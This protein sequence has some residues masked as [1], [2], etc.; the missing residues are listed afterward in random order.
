MRIA[1][2]TFDGFS[3]LDTFIALGFLN[4]LG[5]RGWKA[6]LA[7]PTSD[8]TSM[9]GVTVQ[10]QQ[11]LEFANEADA[12]LFGSGLYSRAIA[13]NSAILDRLQLDPLRQLVGAQCSGALLMARLGLLGDMPACT[14]TATKPWLVEAGVLVVDEPFHARGPIATAGGSMAAQYLAA[15]VMASRA[16]PAAAEEALRHVGPVGEKQDYVD[17]VMGVV[18]PFLTIQSSADAG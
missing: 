18:S 14:D 5:A 7:G 13:E 4:R 11:P 3:E 10:A 1:I 16:G 6:E 15:W 9:N 12:V 17:K 2:V 8:V